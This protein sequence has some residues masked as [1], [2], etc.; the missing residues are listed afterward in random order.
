MEGQPSS[1]D[2][3][4]CPLTWFEVLEHVVDSLLHVFSCL[5]W[6]VGFAIQFIIFVSRKQVCDAQR[7]GA[8][9]RCWTRDGCWRRVS[10]RAT[11]PPVD[12][13]LFDFY[14]TY[15]RQKGQS[16]SE[17]YKEVPLEE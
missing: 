13:D 10:V 11:E 17:V 12:G 3:L 14:S 15:R 2:L 5:A 16:M 1:F 7:S 6:A 4:L 9:S 8:G